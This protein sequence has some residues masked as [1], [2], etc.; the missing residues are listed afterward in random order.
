MARRY[1]YRDAIGPSGATIE[2]DEFIE[3]RKTPRG[4]WVQETYIGFN[5]GRLRF[6]LDGC[7]KRLCHQTKEQAWASFAARKRA[8]LRR[9]KFDAQRAQW[10]VDMVNELGAAPDVGTEPRSPDFLRNV[11]FE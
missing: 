8:Q 9:A 5:V 11:F 6:V 3:V 10:A 1:R 2:I 4:A 7:G